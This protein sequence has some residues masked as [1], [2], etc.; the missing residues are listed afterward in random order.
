VLAVADA[1]RES[2]DDIDVHLIGTPSG[3]EI[4]VVDRYAYHLNLIGGSP[5]LR[6]GAL[7]KVVGLISIGRGVYQARKLLKEKSVDLVIGFGG[8]AS[9]GV[10]VAARSLGIPSAIHESNAKPGLTNE[11]L[12]SLADRIYVGFNAAAQ[13]FP[14]ARTRIVGNPTRSD[15]AEL[16][17]IPRLAPF[18]N[19]RP[20]RLLVTGGS[21]SS[22]FF[23][24]HIPSMLQ[25]VTQQGVSLDVL[26]QV[27]QNDPVPTRTMYERLGVQ[28]SVVPHIEDMVDAHKWADFAI[29]RAGSGTLGELA[30]SG[31]PAL[32]VPL[33]NAARD[34]QTANAREFAA[35]GGGWWIS[36]TEWDTKKVAGRVARIL[37]DE[38]VW[39]N[40]SDS[41]RS[42][43]SPNA[44]M[45]MVAD[46]EA[47]MASA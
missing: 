19:N 44:A 5:V 32:I 28:A 6:V 40:A 26:H 7:R 1:Y 14:E 17:S 47:L 27:G 30:A 24:D 41:A 20:I 8:Y 43:A 4:R 12:G 31:L 37:A 29:T 38:E 39:Q 10:L 34:H 45:A 36:E 9:A 23:N 22:E 11:L 16:A 15:I 33:A 3:Y 35:S 25:R 2:V 42:F 18:S 46:C 13:W 21:N